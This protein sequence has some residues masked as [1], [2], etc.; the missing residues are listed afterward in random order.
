MEYYK[1]FQ[2]IAGYICRASNLAI[3]L[4]SPDTPDCV[5]EVSELLK[6]GKKL[7]SKV[8]EIPTDI[9]QDSSNSKIQ[10][11]PDVLCAFTYA[12]LLE[13]LK[14]MDI[15]NMHQLATSDSSTSCVSSRVKF[16]TRIV[17]KGLSLSSYT[18]NHRNG[19]IEYIPV[20]L[21]SNKSS[22]KM[23]QIL[24]IFHHVRNCTTTG[25]DIQDT[26]ISVLP[27]KAL[28]E[29][30]QH[31]NPFKDWDQ[32]KFDLFYAHP[33][34][35]QIKKDLGL[36]CNMIPEVIALKQVFYPTAS[37]TYASG[38]FGIQSSTIAIK[39]LSRGRHTWS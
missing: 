4:D 15:S 18:V 29:D 7:S 26:F 25:K 9:D 37:Y 33:T 22:P 38:T 6:G 14:L 31:R 1:K 19:I 39:S 23:G 32:L 11:M 16:A 24:N 30:D 8:G 13:R 20:D 2:T 28:D 12:A 34:N 21:T 5:K 36:N 35:D 17:W 10:H 3:L 27:F